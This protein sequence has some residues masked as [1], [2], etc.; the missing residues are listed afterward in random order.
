MIKKQRNQPYAPKVGV[1]SQMGAK[2]KKKIISLVNVSG[3]IG[4]MIQN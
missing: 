1:S 2:K 3:L 4:G